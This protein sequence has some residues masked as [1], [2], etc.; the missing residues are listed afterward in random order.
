MIGA[1]EISDTLEKSTGISSDPFNA[2]AD[3][4]GTPGAVDALWAACFTDAMAD[5]IAAIEA[6]ETPNI[7]ALAQA[8]GAPHF[9]A[10]A[11][12]S[13]TEWRRG[14]QRSLQ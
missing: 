6:G 11:F 2:A 9:V 7:D 4:L 3:W 14:P 10:E 1:L 5:A 8:M 13:F 12:V